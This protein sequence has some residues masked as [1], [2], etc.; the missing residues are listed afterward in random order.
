MRALAL[1]LL[2]SVMVFSGCR[3]GTVEQSGPSPVLPND[4]QTAFLEGNTQFAFRF[5]QKQ[6]FPKAGRKCRT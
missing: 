5:F 4:F 3:N 1:G 6:V 2:A